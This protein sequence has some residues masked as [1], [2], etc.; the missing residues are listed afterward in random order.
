M[1]LNHKDVESSLSR[2]CF[3]YSITL[4]CWTRKQPID[5]DNLQNSR[6]IGIYL[7][8]FSARNFQTHNPNVP[9]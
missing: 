5:T 8:T 4:Q 6:K 9:T 2:T 3:P 1:K 7:R